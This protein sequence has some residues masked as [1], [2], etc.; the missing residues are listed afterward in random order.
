MDIHVILGEPSVAFFN[1]LTLE[2]WQ[3][4]P[5]SLLIVK[6]YHFVFAYYK[7]TNPHYYKVL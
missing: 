6:L 7:K 2:D 3:A 1:A 4:M 5:L